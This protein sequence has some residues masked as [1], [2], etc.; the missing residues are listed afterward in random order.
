MKAS[1]NNRV[2]R[3]GVQT[4][5]LQFEKTGYIFREQPISDYGIDAHIELI[6][7]ENVTGQ[8]IALQ[9][10]SGASWFKEKYDGGYVF[11]GDQKHLDYWL[12]HS[13]PVLIILSDIKAGCCY[14]QA[15][16]SANVRKTKNAWKINIPIYQKI[17][18]GMDVDLKRLVNKLP[19]HKNYTI[20]STDDL[21]HGA[22]KRYSLRIILNREHTQAEIIDLI[23]TVTTEATNCEYH[24]SDIT[25]EHW[26]SSPAHVVWIDVYP[27]AEDEKNN[28]TLCQSEWF[29]ESLAS[30]FKPISNNGEEIAPNIKVSWNNNYLANSRYNS[31]HTMD[32]EYFILQTTW[33]TER[34]KPYIKQALEFLSYYKN[35]G[36]EIEKLGSKMASE[37]ESI[38]EIYDSSGQLGLSSFECKEYLFIRMLSVGL[39]D[40][41]EIFNSR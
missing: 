33:L 21:S 6:D 10:K 16:T 41:N 17:N 9:V 36:G 1:T 40:L 25:R 22:A 32:K 3:V 34:S 20:S 14:W 7:G 12:E 26:G 11:R 19:V 29:S 35:H 18:P 30:D 15:I 2:D 39:I 24:R 13:L 27:S 37:F 8:L 28:N 31:Q 4:V 5:G 23:K 38:D